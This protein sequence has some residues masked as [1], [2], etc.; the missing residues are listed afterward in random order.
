LDSGSYDRRRSDG[1]FGW[2]ERRYLRRCLG[3]VAC[4]IFG[5]IR[6]LI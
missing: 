4:P 5:L 2:I 6:N 3:I 1:R